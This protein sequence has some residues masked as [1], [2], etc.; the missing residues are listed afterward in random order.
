MHEKLNDFSIKTMLTVWAIITILLIF[1][2]L[3]V[4]AYGNKNIPFLTMSCTLNLMLFA[5]IYTFIKK[6]VRATAML[7]NESNDL[8]YIEKYDYELEIG[9][10]L[11]STLFIIVCIIIYFAIFDVHGYTILIK[12]DG[13]IEYV[14]AIFWFIAAITVCY[15]TTKLS[16]IHISRSQLLW[17]VLLMA[18]FIACCGEE[19]SW[20]QRIFHLETPQLLKSVNVQKE[21]TLHNIFCTSFFEN[22]FFLISVIF[23]LVIPYEIKKNTRVENV[24]KYIHLPTPNRF[25]IYVYVGSLFVWVFI[26][27][28]FGTLGFHPFCFYRENYYNQMDDEIFEFLAAYSY[29]CFSILDSTKQTTVINKDMTGT[30]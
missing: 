15:S 4:F 17:N 11:I 13:I 24:L 28:R 27:I 20:G 22:I 9:L 7:I 23:F 16:R 21:I 8:S 12:E 14:S 18:F 5:C 26:G 30:R 6:I 2:V 1:G 29:L 10:A 3:L 25:A 19:L